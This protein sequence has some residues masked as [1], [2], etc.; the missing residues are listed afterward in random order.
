MRRRARCAA[1]SR[2]A[3]GSSRAR[4]GRAASSRC[5]ALGQIA[6]THLGP[7]NDKRFSLDGAELVALLERAGFVDIQLQ[8]ASLEERHQTFPIQGNLAGAGYTNI[9]PAKAA[10]IDAESKA[11]L[12]RFTAANGEITNQSATNVVIA[13]AS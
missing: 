13:R 5:S 10:A 9:D 11:V 3:D 6:E 2:S 8:T 1:C 4:G 7:G 12:A